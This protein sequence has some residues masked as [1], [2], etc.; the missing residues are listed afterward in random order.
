MRKRLRFENRL[1][2]IDVLDEDPLKVSIT[3][4]DSTATI[5]L[6]EAGAGAGRVKLG[7][8]YQ[9]YTVSRV[10]S[11]VWVTL[12]GQTF[13]FEKADQQSAADDDHGGFKAP[14]PGKVIKISIKAGD[15]VEKG[16]ELVVMEAMK[17][18]HRIEAPSQGT[19]TT[20]HCKEGDLVAQ[21]FALLDFQ[22]Q[23]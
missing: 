14:M 19:V 7:S 2:Q 4:D 23:T 13:Q 21:K 3:E 9:P 17:M 10:K 15:K 8:I 11:D 18:E 6:P 20:L 5:S 12:A 16:Q 22:A 1:F